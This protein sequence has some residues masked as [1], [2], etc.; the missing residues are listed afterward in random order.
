MMNRDYLTK[1]E[2]EDM[3]DLVIN[4]YDGYNWEEGGYGDYEQFHF[5]KK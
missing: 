1:E 2:W 3:K 5:V 4:A